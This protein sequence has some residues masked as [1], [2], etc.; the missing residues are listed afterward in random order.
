[1]RRRVTGATTLATLLIASFFIVGFSSQAEAGWGHFHRHHF[2]RHHYHVGFRVGWPSYHYG[3]ARYRVSYPIYHR[4]S[5]PVYRSYIPYNYPAIPYYYPAPYVGHGCFGYGWG[6]GWGYRPWVGYSG[7]YAD[8]SVSADPLPELTPSIMSP[9]YDG[10]SPIVASS[11]PAT[12]TNISLKLNVPEDARVIINDRPTSMTGS[13]R[14]FVVRGGQVQ[15]SYQFVVRAEVERHGHTISETQRVKLN[16]GQAS[17]L[18]FK[19]GTEAEQLVAAN[20]VVSTTVKLHVPADARVFL[21]GKEMKQTGEL[22]VFQTTRLPAGETLQDY[23]VRVVMAEGDA[24][25][26]E[27]TL[28]LIGGQTQEVEFTSEQRLVAR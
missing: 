23:Q 15:D 22:R 1:M 12:G 17:S 21:A 7:F 6:Y 24:L 4:A 5:Y 2:H 16:G 8:S 19:L 20:E 10:T 25:I 26:G 11:Q 13:E 14:T 28:T 3:V 18:S 9:A 27:K